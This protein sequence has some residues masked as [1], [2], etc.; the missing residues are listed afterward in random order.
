MQPAPLGQKLGP[1]AIDNLKSQA[2]GA[3][4]EMWVFLRTVLETV[5]FFSLYFKTEI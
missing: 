5:Y 3:S 2:H 4:P 1:V